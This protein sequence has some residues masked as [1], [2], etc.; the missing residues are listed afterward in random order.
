[1][2]Q[3]EEPKKT[4]NASAM[5]QIL[6]APAIESGVADAVS[7]PWKPLNGI[8]QPNSPS[9]VPL[10]ATVYPVSPV[11]DPVSAVVQKLSSAMI[12]ISAPAPV[13]APIQ[14]LPAEAC[15]RRRVR[16]YPFQRPRC[17]R[18]HARRAVH[19]EGARRRPPDN[20]PSAARL[21]DTGGRSKTALL[22]SEHPPC[23]RAAPFRRQHGA[24]S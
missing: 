6:P 3:A 7:G 11:A 12:P 20:R 14:K 17:S 18:W 2:K 1:M 22:R 24:R 23:P 21:A 13:A 19:T 8:L 10:A 15:R 4:P 16:R 9:V 5:T